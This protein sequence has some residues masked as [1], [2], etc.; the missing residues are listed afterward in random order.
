MCETRLTNGG[1]FVLLDE[2]GATRYGDINLDGDI[3]TADAILL[4]RVLAEQSAISAAAYANADCEF[5]GVLTIADVSLMLRVINGDLE[6][7]ALG[8]H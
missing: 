5:D 8:A 1:V 7:K 2:T 6:A 4:Y 3:T